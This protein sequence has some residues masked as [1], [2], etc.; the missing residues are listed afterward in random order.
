MMGAVES[1]ERR[2]RALNL[3]HPDDQE[4]IRLCERGIDPRMIAAKFGCSLAQIHG[5]LQSEA[6]RQTL[7]ELRAE[8]E[9]KLLEEREEFIKG[10]KKASAVLTAVL[11]D[12]DA[13]WA[14][15]IRAANTILDRDP[16]QLFSK[17][18]RREVLNRVEIGYDRNAFLEHIG[19]VLGQV[20]CLPARVLEARYVEVSDVCEESARV[21]SDELV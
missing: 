18:E 17:T 16:E 6:G 3:L 14:D 13:K 15:K 8:R 7:E 11:D 9:F 10:R 5:L 12:P 1:P 21:E 19:E 4:I 20:E 2:V